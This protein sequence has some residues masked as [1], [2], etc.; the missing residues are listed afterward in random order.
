MPIL[1]I[2]QLS[3]LNKPV[4]F[5]ELH[6]FLWGISVKI[7][8]LALRNSCY[9]LFVQNLFLKIDFSAVF[10]ILIYIVYFPANSM[11]LPTFFYVYSFV[12]LQDVKL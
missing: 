1:D 5:P 4:L 12:I 10:I 2:L 9:Y 8:F 6:Y 7:L 3:F 11:S